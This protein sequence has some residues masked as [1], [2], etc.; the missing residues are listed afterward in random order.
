MLW[1]A[2]MRDASFGL[3]AFTFVNSANRRNDRKK[4]AHSRL[5]HIMQRFTSVYKRIAAV[6]FV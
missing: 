1:I 3:V 6:L 4:I 2:A 5:P